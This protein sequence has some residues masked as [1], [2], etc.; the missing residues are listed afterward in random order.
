M[1]VFWFIP[2]HGD[3]RYLGTSRGGRVLDLGYLQQVASAV[4]NLGFYGALLPTGRSCEDAWV[5]ASFLA[6]NTKRMRFLVAVRPGLVSPTLA[7]RMA[8]TFDRLSNGRILI[9]VVTGGDPVELAGDGL[10]VDHD[11]RYKIT[12]EFLTIWRSVLAN[13]AEVNFEGEQLRVRGAK[14]LFPAAQNPYPALYFGGSSDGA[15]DVAAKHVDYYLTWGE[16]PEQVKEK[17]AKARNY[18]YAKYGRELKFGIRLHIIVRESEEEAWHDAERLI[19]QVTDKTVALAQQTMARQDSVSQQ[20]MLALQKLAGPTRS[21]KDLEISPNLWAG[22]GLVRS[23]A[24]TALVGSVENVVKRMKE[25]AEL[26]IDTFIFSGYPHLEE[27]YR[28]AELLLPNLPLDHG[29]DG[30]ESAADFSPGEV[31]ANDFSPSG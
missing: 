15:I 3:S 14:V 27:A 19:S 7:A 21:R 1:K 8:A 13:E 18:A 5:T 24:G 6:A 4:D 10:F 20:R 16:P 12:D 22:V 17:L 28:T 29:D 26:G 23:G 11:T 25:Y 31:I 30:R 2:T 9:N